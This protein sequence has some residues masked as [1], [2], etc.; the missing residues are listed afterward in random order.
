MGEVASQRKV[1]CDLPATTGRS[2]GGSRLLT[3]V[4][5]FDIKD[6]RSVEVTKSVGFKQGTGFRRKPG[7]GEITMTVYCETGKDPEVD[8]Q[9]AKDDEKIFTWTMQTENNGPRENFTCT[10]SKVDSKGDSEG[11]H[12]DTITLVYTDRYKR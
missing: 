12:E 8:W 11:M 1:Y 10:V 5:E 7:G 6:D 9:K 4:K 3:K 2:P